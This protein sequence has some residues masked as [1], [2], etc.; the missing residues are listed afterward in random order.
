MLPAAAAPGGGEREVKFVWVNMFV[1]DMLCLRGMICYR[2]CVGSNNLMKNHLGAPARDD[3]RTND[4]K[5]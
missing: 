2:V 3:L 4:P 1:Q 5:Q